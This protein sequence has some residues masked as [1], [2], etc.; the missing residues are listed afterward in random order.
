MA[1]GFSIGDGIAILGLIERIATEIK[2]YR[3]APE[4]FQQL[5]VELD[6]LHQV[7][8]RLRQVNATSSNQ[9]EVANFERIKAIAT[10]CEGPLKE[11]LDKMNTHEPFLGKHKVTGGLKGIGKRLHWSTSIGKKEVG[12]LRA[13]VVSQV[14]A[15]NTLLNAQQ[16]ECLQALD[17]CQGANARALE[18]LISTTTAFAQRM[19]LYFRDKDDLQ[20]KIQQVID[21]MT[22]DRQSNSEQ[23]LL[24]GTKITASN[25]LDTEDDIEELQGYLA[26]RSKARGGLEDVGYSHSA[27]EQKS[28]AVL[29]RIASYSS[30]LLRAIQSNTQMLLQLSAVLKTLERWLP[31]QID[32]PIIRFDDALGNT[33]A[34]PLQMCSEWKV[35]CASSTKVFGSRSTDADKRQTFR[36]LLKHMYHFDDARDRVRQGLFLITNAKGGRI[37]KSHNWKHSL[38]SGDHLSM[39]MIVT[40]S[41]E[42][43]DICPFPQCNGIL[44]QEA[45]SDG[46][47][48]C[49]K[50]G[51]WTHK[52]PRDRDTSGNAHNLRPSSFSA[53]QSSPVAK[54]VTPSSDFEF[55]K[56]RDHPDLKLYRRIAVAWPGSTISGEDSPL[57]ANA[58]SQDGGHSQ[59]T[60]PGLSATT[61]S[62]DHPPSTLL[63]PTEQITRFEPELPDSGIAEPSLIDQI[64]ADYDVPVF[65]D[66][67]SYEG[68]IRSP[69]AMTDDF[70]AWLFDDSNFKNQWRNSQERNLPTPNSSGL[71]KLN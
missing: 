1:F 17:N 69:F 27:F 41:G 2:D 5:A 55:G 25:S 22:T 20:N 62:I 67:H 45:L 63:S 18:D 24:L 71:P 64:V 49:P 28:D 3:H 37:L 4:H 48:A 35:N 8:Q 19:E 11:F 32:L 12:E 34:L 36:K 29:R 56:L 15:I 13:V 31:R 21:L 26:A 7:L 53:E 58:T 39:S 16:W 33:I 59:R 65:E 54:T 10:H 14:L 57:Q 40:T 23:R 68:R 30:E 70:T 66:Q 44:G 50:C 61:K 42:P 43:N 46:A 60:P 51:R 47:Y 6:F 52:L 9:D 38:V